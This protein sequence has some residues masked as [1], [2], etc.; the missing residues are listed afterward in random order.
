MDNREKV[1]LAFGICTASAV[2]SIVFAACS[3]RDVA[4][5]KKILGESVDRIRNM[6]RIDIDQRVI[7]DAVSKVVRE[8]SGDAV[9]AAVNRVETAANADIQ[10]R[11]RQAVEKQYGRIGDKVAKR[12]AEEISD[13]YSRQDIID[14][15]VSQTVDKLTEKIGDELDSEIGKIGKVYQGIAA[16]L[17]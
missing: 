16:A 15:V 12:I 2:V 11:V 13:K 14:E 9:R 1:A 17:K 4:D 10:N 8:K 3:A 7:N 6:S 5:T